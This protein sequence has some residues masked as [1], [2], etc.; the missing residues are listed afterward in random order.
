MIVNSSDEPASARREAAWDAVRRAVVGR[1]ATP[2]PRLVTLL[3]YL[4]DVRAVEAG[5]NPVSGVA[6]TWSVDGPVE[7]TGMRTSVG[8]G[9]NVADIADDAVAVTVAEYGAAPLEDLIIA[10]AQTKPV[11]RFLQDGVPGDELDLWVLSP[12]P[13]ISRATLRWR[14]VA[15][16]L[17]NVADTPGVV[18]DLK[19]ESNAL[20]PERDRANGPT[21]GDA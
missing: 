7:V 16:Q 12:V 1:G 13:D 5:G 4:V 15:Y 21:F 17:P 8:P 18:E 6:W 20:R 10:A 14:A 3:L 2:S 9:S 19:Q 11:V